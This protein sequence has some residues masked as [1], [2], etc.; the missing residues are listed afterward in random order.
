MR[1]LIAILLISTL[2]TAGQ[3]PKAP[4]KFQVDS[5][6]VVVNV[7]AKDKSGAPLDGL[8]AN[9]FTITE[10]GKA[11]SIKVFEFQRLEEAALPQPEAAAPVAA[12]AA[13]TVKAP[14]SNAIAPANPG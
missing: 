1:T 4:I 9:D 14:T 2:P 11:Q 8:K 5:Q 12:A 10:D 3:T 13:A 6:L 7:A